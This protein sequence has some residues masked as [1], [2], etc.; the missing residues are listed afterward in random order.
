MFRLS[1]KFTKIVGGWSFAP[2]STGGAYNAPQTPYSWIEPLGVFGA[3]AHAQS[4]RASSFYRPVAALGYIKNH[5]R[6]L[7]LGREQLQTQKDVCRRSRTWWSTV[8]EWS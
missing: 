8:A 5:G 4:A 2:D 6:A 7:T 3:S 1:L